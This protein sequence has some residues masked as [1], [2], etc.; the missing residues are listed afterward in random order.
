MNMYTMKMYADCT[1]REVIFKFG[2]DDRDY[3]ALH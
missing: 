3:L 2:N 1:E